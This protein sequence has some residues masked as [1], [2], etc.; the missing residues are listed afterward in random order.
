MT[1]NDWQGDRARGPLRGE[2]R[3]PGDK[4][5]GHR[6]VLFPLLG[7]GSSRVRG[8]PD[9]EDVGC[10][11]RAARALGAEIQVDP[12]GCT[13]RT[14]ARLREPAD[15]LDCG[16]SG[17]SIRLLAGLIAADPVYAVLSGDASLRRRPMARILDPL[18]RAGV[19]VD[20]REGGKQAPI[21]VRGPVRSPVVEDLAVASAQVKTALL[22]A[23]RHVGARVREPAQSRDHTERLLS[24]MG[25]HLHR[26]D[27]GYLAL[28]PG[29]FTPVD[30]EVPGD[31]SS[32][33]FWLVA[34]SLVPGSELTICGVGVNPTRTGA[35][36]VLRAMGANIRVE[37]CGSGPE[38][39]ADL[40]VRAADLRGVTIAGDLALRAL[41]ELPVLAIAA[42]F[43]EGP[44]VIADA[45]EL[46]VKES[47]RVARVVSGLQ[48]LAVD[49]E[50]RPD[51]MVIHGGGARPGARVDATGD[52]RIAMAFAVAALRAG[53]IQIGGMEAIGSSYPGFLRDL[54]RVAGR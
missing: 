49:A 43:A 34:A 51:G 5:I 11:L 15:V 39:T 44:T 9:G 21:T 37:P 53:P 4:S 18:R 2:L 48:S 28:A 13:I 54:R 8:L 41:D 50:E 47:D 24:A 42:A 33:A 14:V 16:N 27:A 3:V 52:H 7:A 12:D 29:G 25:A 10:T 19:A 20:G 35:L 6:A 38:P 32:A 17:T 22:L 30:L 46:R 40:T 45:T 1:A 26:D 23:G 31:F 36:D